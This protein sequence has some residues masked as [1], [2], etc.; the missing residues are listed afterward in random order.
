MATPITTIEE[1][2]AAIM[3]AESSLDNVDMMYLGV[4]YAV[5]AEYNI[6]SIITIDTERTERQMT[7]ARHERVYLGSIIVN[8]RQQDN[9]FTAIGG[10]GRVQRV[11]SYS[12]MQTLGNAVVDLFK[13]TANQSLQNL[14]FVTGGVTEMIIGDEAVQYG[15]EATQERIDAYRNSVVIPFAVATLETM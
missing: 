10:S 8:V 4:P 5:P 1:Q 7:G 13:Q 9:P 3:V 6:W 2:I 11:S 14:T 15:I 12:T